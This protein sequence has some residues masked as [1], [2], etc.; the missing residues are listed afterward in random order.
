MKYPKTT[1]AR[2]K[3]VCQNCGL[4]HRQNK[5]QEP[6][7]S[8]GIIHVEVDFFGGEHQ[9]VNEMKAKFA[10]LSN[11]V[12]VAPPVY[13]NP[14]LLSFHQELEQYVKFVMVSRRVSLGFSQFARGMYQPTDP[15]SIKSL[16]RQMYPK[17]QEIIA[18]RDY[19]KIIAH[20][21]NIAGSVNHR[22]LVRKFHIPYL[23]F[24]ALVENGSQY[25]LDYYLSIVPD[26][27]CDEWGFPKGRMQRNREHPLDCAVREFCE[28]TGREPSQINIL[29]NISPLEEN[30]IG[31]NGQP[32]RHIYYLSISVVSPRETKYD[33]DPLEIGRVRSAGYYEAI[34]M[35][36]PYHLEKKQV[37]RHVFHFL[38]AQLVSYCIQNTP[39]VSA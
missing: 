20:Y 37:M 24:R 39:S 7:T 30:M 2:Q 5:C 33:P 8:Y 26:Y 21:D 4:E 32:Y 27:Q 31:T 15:S 16:F 29:H 10:A 28:E 38:I 11:H 35:I 9:F 1:S 23:K 34:Q 3:P 25:D 13:T 14:M 6:V 36:R 12:T 17:E 19:H 18:T 22:Y